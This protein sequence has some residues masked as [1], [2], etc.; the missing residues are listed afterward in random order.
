[1]LE[2]LHAGNGHHV[3]MVPRSFRLL[4]SFFTNAH[5]L[6]RPTIVQASWAAQVLVRAAPLLPALAIQIKARPTLAAFKQ[7]PKTNAEE[8]LRTR[9]GIV[10]LV[11]MGVA[12]LRLWG[13]QMTLPRLSMQHWEGHHAFKQT[14]VPSVVVMH[15]DIMVLVLVHDVWR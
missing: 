14:S 13:R 4:S 2:V 15:S 7:H 9:P 6:C 5:Q 11:E 8:P 10:P 1:M 12:V 3:V